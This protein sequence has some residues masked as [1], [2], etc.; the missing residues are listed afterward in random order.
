[1]VEG[2][3]G[4][5]VYVADRYDELMKTNLQSGMTEEEADYAAKLQV[6]KELGMSALYDLSMGMAYGLGRS[7][8]EVRRSLTR[9]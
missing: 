5:G 8:N 3:V 1:M 2:V 9:K 4:E 6:L 7:D